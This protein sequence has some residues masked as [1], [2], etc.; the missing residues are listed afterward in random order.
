MTN[1]DAP[2]PGPDP[3]PKAPAAA[4]NSPP[5]AAAPTPPAAP[6]D[7]PHGRVGHVAILGRP[8]AGKSTFLNAVL[9]YR[10]VAVSDKPQTT[11]QRW[12][13]IRSDAESQMLF[14]DT[15]GVH[16]PRNVLGEAMAQAIRRALGDADVVLCLADPTRAL[17]REDQLVA[18][19]AAH[20]GKPVVLGVNKTD[21]ATPA[22]IEASE[23][24]YAQ[25][26]P[27]AVRV[28]FAAV[29]PPT[30]VAVTTAIKG[31]LP[32]G[33]FLYPPDAVTDSF[34]R[35]IGAELIREAALTY[36]HEEVPHGL[37]VTIE[38]WDERP[39]ER[40]VA[41][42]IHVE[43]ESHKPIVL[44][45]GGAM[46]GRIREMATARLTEMCG[47]TVRLRLFVKVSEDWRQNRMF[48]RE[49]LL[50]HGHD[51]LGT[52]PEQDE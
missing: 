34:E 18:E 46:L 2:K 28:R 23:A 1:P 20:S 14:I 13:G 5:T 17:G 15:P 44:G 36:L 42:V 33:P 48:V 51:G 22:Q 38:S 27:A 45:H 40:R 35:D 49:L 39:D 7:W 21:L 43:R 52:R 12:L 31:L 37:A 50:P 4:P 41:A 32:Q 29:Q 6:A 47:C 19:M 3:S 16:A 8:N 9:D 25:A 10:L 30:L 24:F 26:L 11:R